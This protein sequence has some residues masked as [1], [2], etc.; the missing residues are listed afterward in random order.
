MIEDFGSFQDRVSEVRKSIREACLG[1]GRDPDEVLLLAVT[2]SH[3]A[4]AI[5]YAERAGIIVVGE[6]RVQEAT[7]KKREVSPEAIRPA[8]AEGS[9]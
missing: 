1:C 4:F 3:P 7:R 5:E 9:R 6:N 8:P 2:K